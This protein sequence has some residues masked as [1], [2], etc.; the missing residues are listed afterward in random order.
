MLLKLHILFIQFLRMKLKK[1]IILLIQTQIQQH[2]KINIAPHHR[3]GSQ[4]LNV[5]RAYLIIV[6]FPK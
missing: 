5:I 1:D 2:C 4:H 3:I 6:F